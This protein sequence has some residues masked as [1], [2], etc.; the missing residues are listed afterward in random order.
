MDVFEDTLNSLLKV[1]RLNDAQK[2]GVVRSF[3]AGVFSKVASDF[4]VLVEAD[5]V[6]SSKKSAIEDQIDNALELSAQGKIPFDQVLLTLNNLIVASF[7]E[8]RWAHLIGESFSFHLVDLAASLYEQKLLTD[9][10][11]IKQQQVL[12]GFTRAKG[13]DDSLSVGDKLQE[14]A[15]K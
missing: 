4:L 2:D 3:F 5:A 10:D 9:E 15:K 14:L 12:Q 6:L 8:V 7:G 1:A 13:L 11:F